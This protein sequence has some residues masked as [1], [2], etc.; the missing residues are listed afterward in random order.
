MADRNT[1]RGG[2]GN[3]QGSDRPR[4]GGPRKPGGNRGPAKGA[5]REGG[6]PQRDGE[7]RTPRDAEKRE[8]KPREGGER[9]PARDGEKRD[10]ERR[11]WKPREGGDRRA[12]RDGER[13]EWKPREGGDRRPPRDGE[14]REY[15]PRDG[16]RPRGP[17]KEYG[18][19]P[20]PQRDRNTGERMPREARPEL[21][22]EQL[23][24]RALRPVRAE[25]ED[26]PIDDD[27]LLKMLDRQAFNELKALTEENAEFVGSHLVMA[28]RYI[29]EDPAKALSH[30][31][32]AVRRGGRL[33]C[34]REA[35]GVAAYATGDFAL[36]L[37]EL[38][39]FNRIS[40]SNEQIALIVDSE[41]GL[42]R[43]EKALEL[44]RSVDRTK[45][46]DA[47]AATLAIAMSGARLDLG[48][49]DMAL[50]ELE[51]P[52]LDPNTAFSYS[53]SLFWAF[54]E[55]LEE[56]G[57]TKE[58]A[59]W[60]QRADV[61]QAALDETYGTAEEF[62]DQTIL[63]EYPEDDGADF[64]ELNLPEDQEPIADT[65]AEDEQ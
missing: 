33:A 58:A 26:L 46:S 2:A 11:E 36:A 40:G 25:H 51:I 16:E 15:K 64:D 57:R 47:A 20:A 49:A 4:S 65:A 17:R 63:I 34:V 32:S 60:R 5:P 62:E 48:Q 7:R 29:D 52:Q 38:R 61:A 12:P 53:P 31:Q 10:G 30:A 1:P 22:E 35:A 43:P 54:A 39:T 44:G 45:L 50:A 28:A 42:E 9:R 37:R 13:R 21:T 59:T 18:D 19:R 23:R 3:G 56:L 55:V 27:V 6:R 8:W 24:A 14:R 41:R